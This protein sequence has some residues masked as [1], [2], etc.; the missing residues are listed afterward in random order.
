[1]NIIAFML[2][3]IRPFTKYL[4]GPFAV[5]IFH[6]VDNSF[7]PYLIKLMIDGVGGQAISL[8]GLTS[9]W[10]IAVLFCFLQFL[11]SCLWAFYEWCALCYEPAMKNHISSFLLSH[12]T[13]HDYSYFQNNFA[14]NLAAKISDVIK[15]I[16]DIW[17]IVIFNFF[18]SFL[19]ILIAMYT[20]WKIHYLFAVAIGVWAFLMIVVM[21]ASLSRFDFLTQRVAEASARAMG[22]MVDTITNMLA[23]R[24]FARRKFE[25]ENLKGP[26]ENYLH[27]SRKRRWFT[28]IFWL[29]Q[30][31]GF[32]IYQSTVL[33]LLLTL[34]GKGHITAGDFGMIL[35]VNLL[36]LEN[37][38][39][40][41]D[42]V[43]YFSEYW[44]TVGQAL[45]VFY[46]PLAQI[47]K[48]NAKPLR[49]TAGKISFDQ[50]RFFYK[51]A[52]PLFYNKSVTIKAGEKVGLVGYSG[53]GKTTF[54]N[55]ILRLFDVSSGAILIDDQSVKDVTQG[56][57]RE[58]IAMIPQ[59]PSLFHRS[60]MD[61]IRYGRLEATD[62]EVIEAA[63]K[64]H[65]HNFIMALPQKYQTMVGERGLKLSGGQR[66][67]ISIA[68]AIL[69]NAP[70]LVLD[71]ATSQLDTITEQEIQ[72][73]LT[74]F[75]KD[76]T[77][78][79]IAHRLS[80]LLSMD[81]ILVFEKGKIVQD[82]SHKELIEQN[83][84]YKTLW[85]AQVCGFLPN[86]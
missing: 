75:M 30:S 62:E 56:S 45:K 82:G 1:M 64:A 25:I 52:E 53:S 77:S 71:E 60:I 2:H 32:V 51:G 86:T 44:G 70:I 84:L 68:R 38:N 47:D 4:I 79:V 34:Y 49:V 54:V 85:N 23:V 11:I 33:Y 22:H 15:L 36:I 55:L 81:R 26:Q 13:R 16:P 73:A 6:A 65:A 61:N 41:A 69:K 72:F 17:N 10:H 59:E 83:G 31:Q 43:R 57:L 18:S 46:A 37:L 5:V 58:S 40:L 42:Q 3:S 21:V 80:T 35:T 48:P 39:K 9:L 74:D 66:Q 63:K 78:V 27:A 12:L 14:G 8:G 19:S 24:L 28:L 76:K 50:V 67:R 7:R 20:L 29:I